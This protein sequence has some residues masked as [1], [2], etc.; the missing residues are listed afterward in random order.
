MRPGA[1]DPKRHSIRLTQR[2]GFAGVHPQESAWILDPRIDR[3]IASTRTRK[4]DQVSSNRDHNDV[5][6]AE[7]D[8]E[9]MNWIAVAHAL[10][11]S[12]GRR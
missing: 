9:P 12:V 6:P 8:A 5:K 4:R 11:E 10:G 2:A 3:P 1:A 7:V